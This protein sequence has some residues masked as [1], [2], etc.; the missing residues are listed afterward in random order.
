M[1]TM[2]TE[3]LTYSVLPCSY[4][5]KMTAQGW[6]DISLDHTT[7]RCHPIYRLEQPERMNRAISTPGAKMQKNIYLSRTDACHEV[8]CRLDWLVIQ[9][10]IWLVQQPHAICSPLSTDQDK[11]MARAIKMGKIMFS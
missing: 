4:R 2:H 6:L 7:G 3:T 5:L 8:R 9:T 1:G 11:V 10:N